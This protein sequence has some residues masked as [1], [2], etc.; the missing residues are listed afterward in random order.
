MPKT[1][2]WLPRVAFDTAFFIWVGV[3][4]F[5]S[6]TALL[7]DS[8]GKARADGARREAEERNVCYMCGLLRHDYEDS[9]LAPGSPSFDQHCGDPPPPLYK[10]L[11]ITTFW[12]VFASVQ[13]K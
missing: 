13:T 12:I 8:L 5:T 2:D 4:L 3:I 9:G 11:S 1:K 6:I 7:V 10:Q